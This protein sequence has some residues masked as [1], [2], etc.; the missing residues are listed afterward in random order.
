MIISS[1]NVRGMNDPLRQQEVLEFL[2]RNKVD[3]GA[4]IETH[5]K[6]YLAQV[7]YKRQFSSYSLATNYNSHPGGRIWLLWNPATVQVRVLDSGAQFLHCSLLHFSS[8]KHILLTVVYAF[9][10]AQE[11]IEL[12]NAL[13]SLSHGPVDPGSSV[14]FLPSGV[15]DHS[16]ILLTVV[17]THTIHKPFRY[18][19][20]LRPMLKQLHSQD[21]T[22]LTSRVAAAKLKLQDCQ[23]LLQ[24][25]PLNHVLL[26]QEKHLL[27]QYRLVKEDEMRMLSQKAKIHHLKLS[28]MNTRFFY[29]SIAV[30]KAKNTIGIITDAQGQLCQGHQQVTQ[31]FLNYYQN[32]LGTA[33]PNA[34]LPANL[35]QENVLCQV[36]HLNNMV[37]TSEIETALF[38]IDRNKS[39]GVD[40]FSS[41]FFKDTWATLRA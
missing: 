13:K 32:L 10:R 3:C 15:S 8:Q 27:H 33:E 36:P 17:A 14:A 41:R 22:N 2:K 4:V 11:R 25:S 37:T 24:D 34:A 39:P 29:A 30:R 7:I 6:S 40:G 20:S 18:L 38:S 28:D 9:N 19:N 35:F 23:L 26:L 12:W 5:I 1:W 21:Y 16:S 31:A